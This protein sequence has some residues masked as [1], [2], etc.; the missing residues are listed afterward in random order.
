MEKSEKKRVKM[1]LHLG[2]AL[3]PCYLMA[4]IHPNSPLRGHQELMRWHNECP[5][6]LNS[7]VKRHQQNKYMQITW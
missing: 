3:S 5:S 2:Q 6:I 7:E 1:G 4:Y